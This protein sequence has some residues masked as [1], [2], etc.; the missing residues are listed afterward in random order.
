MS[1]IRLLRKAEAEDHQ[2]AL[3]VDMLKEL[4]ETA[5]AA[6]NAFESAQARLIEDLA[7]YSDIG[8][9][10]HYRAKV[11]RKDSVKI[12]ET[13]LKKALGAVLFR[14]ATKTVLDRKK[15]DE[16]MSTGEIDPVVV[17][18][19]SEISPQKPYLSFSKVF[20]EG[21]DEV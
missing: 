17:S 16:L 13:G 2:I 4:K 18:T 14:K 21:A 12:N 11:V 5:V 9:G 19:Y 7:E 1:G 20:E 3:R 10:M 15:L 8:I 6:Q